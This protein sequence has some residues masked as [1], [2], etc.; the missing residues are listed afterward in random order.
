MR[1]GILYVVSS[2][3]V[4]AAVNAIV[5]WLAARYSVVEIIAFR[6]SFALLP[7]LVLIA[8]HGGWRVLRTH[9]LREHVSRAALQFVSMSCIF[10]AFAMMPLADAIA[11]T[12][13]SPLF[14]T[15]LSIPLLGEQVRIHRWSAVVVGFVGVLIMLPPSA[16]ILHGGAVF[17]LTNAIMN[18]LLTIAVRRMSVTEASTALVVYQTL[19]TGVIGLALL[20]FFWTAP[21]LFDIVLFAATGLLSGIGQYWWTQA[22]RFLPAAVAAPFSYT[23]MVWSLLLGFAIWGDVPTRSVLYGAVIVIASGLYIL[24][25]ET[26]RRV[27]KRRWHRP[28][29][30][31]VP[32]MR[33]AGCGGSLPLKVRSLP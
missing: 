9:R 26:V 2:I 22:Y 21:T 10:T 14:L 27:A 5:K 12:F 28:G 15:V 3:F 1:R 20:P 18:A 7:C 33:Q 32:G 24:Y 11:I 31:D 4:F 25:R 30:T 6:S 13:S 16:G 23:S 29:I 8:T 17:A 19:V